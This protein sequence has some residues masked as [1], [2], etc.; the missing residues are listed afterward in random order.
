MYERREKYEPVQRMEDILTGI[1]AIAERRAELF[2]RGI[3][4]E[5]LFTAAYLLCILPNW[6]KPAQYTQYMQVIRPQLIQGTSISMDAYSRVKSFFTEQILSLAPDQVIAR[7]QKSPLFPRVPG[8]EVP[9]PQIIDFRILP[10][11]W[12]LPGAE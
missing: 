9:P 6:P 7:L 11:D 5:D 2:H 1:F 12:P 3:T 4:T 8:M 10:P